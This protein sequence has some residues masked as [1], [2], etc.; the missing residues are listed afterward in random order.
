MLHGCT[1][2][3]PAGTKKK[4]ISGHNTLGLNTTYME[5]VKKKR[6]NTYVDTWKLSKKE[7]N[8]YVDRTQIDVRTQH[9]ATLRKGTVQ[10]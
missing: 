1:D 3:Y 7:K 2:R 5:V 10:R 6:K 4:M 9:V 8:T